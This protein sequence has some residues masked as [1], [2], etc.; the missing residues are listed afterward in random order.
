MGGRN[1]LLPHCWAYK[2]GGGGEEEELISRLL[3]YFVF[4]KHGRHMSEKFTS[5]TK[6]YGLFLVFG[7]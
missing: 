4:I 7:C 3:Q 5:C 6:V 1:F 2:R